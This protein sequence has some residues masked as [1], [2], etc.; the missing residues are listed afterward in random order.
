MYLHVPPCPPASHRWAANLPV[1]L[2]YPPLRGCVCSLSDLVEFH[3]VHDAILLVAQP[4]TETCYIWLPAMPS[5]ALHHRT[6]SRARRCVN[7]SHDL[8]PNSRL[9]DFFQRSAMLESG[10]ESL[11]PCCQHCAESCFIRVFF[12]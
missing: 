11:S 6:E 5:Y 8:C 7:L 12:S 4:K 2:L 10:A 3:P 1:A 9:N